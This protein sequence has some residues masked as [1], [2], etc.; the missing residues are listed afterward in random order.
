MTISEVAKKLGFSTYTLR[1][2][3]KIGLIRGVRRSG[4]IRRYGESDIKWLEFIGR[5]KSTGM[6]LA[7]IAQYAKLRYEGDDTI[8]RR[9][10]MLL[11]HR[12]RLRREIE[13]LQNH[14]EALEKKIQTYEHMEREYESIRKGLEKS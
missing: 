4:G 7:E 2:Y 1:Y 10:D 14:Y 13:N 9:K 5:L 8:S 3:E 11:S 12:A 6:P